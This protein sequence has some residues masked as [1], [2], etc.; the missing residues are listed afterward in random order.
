QTSYFGFGIIFAITA[1]GGGGGSGSDSGAQINN[2]T[3][4]VVNGA[5]PAPVLRDDIEPNATATTIAA[6]F[7]KSGNGYP[8]FF[9]VASYLRGTFD[10][11]DTTPAKSF[12]MYLENNSG[13]YVDR[14]EEVFGAR[15]INYSAREIR[16]A[17][18]NN[19]NVQ[20]IM[21]VTNNEDGRTTVNPDHIT[22]PLLLFLSQANGTYQQFEIGLNVWSHEGA[23]GDFDDDGVLE[24]V[25]AGF[26]IHSSHGI[27]PQD[28]SSPIYEV[29]P[30]GSWNID[31][32]IGNNP[33]FGSSETRFELFDSDTCLD[34]ITSAG[35]GMTYY[36][37]NCDGTFTEIEHFATSNN[38]YLTIPGETYS[39]DATD[40]SVTE[41]DGQWVAGPAADWAEVFDIDNDGDPDVVYGIVGMPVS[42]DDM[43]SGYIVQ[44]G[45]EIPF[46]RSYALLNSGGILNRI[47]S[48]L[49]NLAEGINLNWAHEFD[50]NNDGFLDLVL[51]EPS[52]GMEETIFL[53]HGDGTFEQPALS[54]EG[55]NIHTYLVPLDYNLDGLPDFISRTNYSLNDTGDFVLLRGLRTPAF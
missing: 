9:M 20:D 6:V 16:T 37:G 39:G 54:L 34:L 24:F 26:W 15:N 53:S 48:P 55:G 43:L 52:L 5:L 21:L 19:D 30:D 27:P 8:D 42:Q 2:Y 1:C 11:I 31:P 18:V 47:S 46:V 28:G 17:D 41:I 25:D 7:D 12:I 40:W 29:H 49:S 33:L 50:L 32:V 3:F 35:D 14:T 51:D 13:S 36:T 4:E 10:Q 22:A 38:A 45:A 44:T 23:F